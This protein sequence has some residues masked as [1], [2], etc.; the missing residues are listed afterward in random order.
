MLVDP[1]GPLATAAGAEEFAR[2]EGLAIVSVEA[3]RDYLQSAP[4][5]LEA[6]HDHG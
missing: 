1:D 2:A 4:E 3:L 6:A 5:H